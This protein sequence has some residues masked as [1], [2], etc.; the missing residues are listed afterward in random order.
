M[1]INIVV[2]SAFSDHPSVP[3]KVCE[4]TTFG[5]PIVP[6]D[7]GPAGGFGSLKSLLQDIF[8]IYANRKVSPPLLA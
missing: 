2:P 4:D 7:V 5:V 3:E 6:T 8:A 1:R